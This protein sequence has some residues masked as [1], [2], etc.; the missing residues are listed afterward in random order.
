MVPQEFIWV[1][2]I[3]K[4]RVLNEQDLIQLGNFYNLCAIK[5]ISKEIMKE[6]KPGRWKKTKKQL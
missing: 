4:N 2:Y 1:V 5:N 6:K 3:A